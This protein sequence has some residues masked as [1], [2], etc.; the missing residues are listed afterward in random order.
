[1]NMNDYRK[2]TD[3]LEA[4][5]R[6]RK[7]VLDMSRR[8]NRIKLDTKDYEEKVSGVEVRRGHNAMR[9]IGIA[10]AI[11]IVAGGVGGTG[12]FLHKNGRNASQITDISRE[13]S[14]EPAEESTEEATFT[15]ATV[16]YDYE[17]IANEL[18]QHYVDSLNVLQYGE[19]AYDSSDSITFYTYDST[20]EEWSNNY[21]GERTFYKVT[22]VRFKNCQDIYEYYKEPIAPSISRKHY[23]ETYENCTMPDNYKDANGFEFGATLKSWLG[24]D[25]S[26]F[27]SGS[28]VDIRPDGKGTADDEAFSINSG[29]YIEYNGGLYVSKSTV[30]PENAPYY[31]NGKH[32]FPI[33]ITTEPQILGI[34]EDSFVASCFIKMPYTGMENAKYGEEKLITFNLI[35]GEWKISSIETGDRPEYTSAV[36]IQRYIEQRQEYNDINIGCDSEKSTARGIGHITDKL[37]VTEYDP[38]IHVCKVHVVLHNMNGEDAL[39]M[40]AEISVNYKGNPVVMSADITRIKEYD[41]SYER[42]NAV[43]AN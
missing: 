6:C 18:T 11:A 21:G 16:E 10:A 36:A 23:G 12:V 13:E 32:S 4:D 19:V 29:I 17:A 43:S 37:E 3:R 9:Y 24:G 5:E 34:N 14:T 42:P 1:M 2:V 38:N 30:E 20:N 15:V 40:T 31:A 22:D 25:V 35:D 26:K 8:E 27:E 39:D 41:S 7:E 28:R 33:S